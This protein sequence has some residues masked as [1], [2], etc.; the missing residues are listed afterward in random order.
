MTLSTEQRF[1]QCLA[2]GMAFQGGTLAQRGK[3]AEGTTQ[4]R[5]SLAA[6]RATGVE[7]LGTYLMALLAGAYGMVGQ[8]EERRRVVGDALTAVS[9]TEERWYEAESIGSRENYAYNRLA[10]TRTMPN[11]ASTSPLPLPASSRR[12]PYSEWCIGEKARVVTALT[13]VPMATR[14][15][16]SRFAAMTWGGRVR[17]Y[18]QAIGQLLPAEPKMRQA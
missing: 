14:G 10:P 4:I 3:S 11:G 8:A 1:P 6:W 9:K 17:K 13:Q 15:D 5:W 7:L 12:N 2:A 18:H 16:T